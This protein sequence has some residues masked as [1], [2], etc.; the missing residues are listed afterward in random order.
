MQTV[1]TLNEGLKRAYKITIPA[2]DIDARVDK[3]LKTVAPRIQMPGFRPGKVPANLVRK[4]HGPALQQEA[5]NSAVQESV[6]QLLAEQQLRPAMQP[7]VELE[8]GGLGKDAVINVELE[9]LPD[10]PE[11]KI[12]GLKLERLTVEADDATVD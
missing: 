9:T 11:P 10:V 3:E 6:Q 2:K 7:S 1:E 5:L 4:I 8:E 12:D